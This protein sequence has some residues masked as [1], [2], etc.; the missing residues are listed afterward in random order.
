MEAARLSSAISCGDAG[1]LS[2]RVNFQKCNLLGSRTGA[3]GGTDARLH[4]HLT[5]MDPT[6]LIKGAAG[7]SLDSH[8][9]W[10]SR[11]ETLMITAVEM[12]HQLARHAFFDFSK[13]VEVPRWAEQSAI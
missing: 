9:S 12:S 5:Y 13:S 4:E 1:S 3:A 10:T 2:V 11:Y 7:Y 8:I 6:E